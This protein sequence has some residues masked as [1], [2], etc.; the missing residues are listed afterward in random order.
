MLNGTKHTTI[1]IL[2]NIILSLYSRCAVQH[3]LHLRYIMMQP[4]KLEPG[5]QAHKYL[6][7]RKRIIEC[8]QLVLLSNEGLF[9][10]TQESQLGSLFEFMS[11]RQTAFS[12]LSDHSFI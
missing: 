5:H 9:M 3:I 2:T 11:I 7:H 4:T 10:V 6:A 8:H 12:I 1:A